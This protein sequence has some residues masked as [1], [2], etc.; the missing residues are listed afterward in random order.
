MIVMVYVGKSLSKM[1]RLF[2][3]NMQPCPFLSNRIKKGEET[4]DFLAYDKLKLMK[5]H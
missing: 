4:L 2:H 1:R 3:S 5:V